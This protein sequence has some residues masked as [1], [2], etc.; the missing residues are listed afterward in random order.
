MTH[1]IAL[2]WRGDIPLARAFWFYA[3]ACGALFNLIGTIL[4]FAVVASDGAAW[5]AIMAFLL[6]LPFNVFAVIV[7]WRSAANAARVAVILW[8]VLLTLL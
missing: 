6:P 7:V 2:L 3:V 5:L 1:R 8:A 4:G